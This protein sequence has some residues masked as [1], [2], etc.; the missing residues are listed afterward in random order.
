M[1]ARLLRTSLPL[2]TLVMSFASVSS[3]QP[4]QPPA[5]APAEPAAAGGAATGSELPPS[6]IQNELERR[7]AAMKA[8][9]GLTA[10]EVA[11]RALKN[12]QALEAKRH[13]LEAADAGVSQ[14]NAGYWPQLTASAR[15]TRLSSIEQANLGGGALVVTQVPAPNPR[16]IAAG[17]Q[18]FATNLSFP[19]LLNQYTL[20]LQLNVPLSD[21]LLRTS[22]AVGSAKHSRAAAELDE[23]GTR[24]SLARDARVAYYE[25]VRAQAAELIAAQGVEQAQG[26]LSDAQNAFQAGIV[27]RADVLR[28]E[29]ALQGAALFQER[30]RNASSLAGLRLKVLM[31]DE[32]SQ[33]YEVG[34]NVFAPLPELETAPSAESAYQEALEKRTELRSLE[35]AEAALRQQGQVARAGNY[36]RLDA[37]ANV[38]YANPNQRYFPQEDKWRGTWD[39]SLILSWTPT[40]IA[41]AQAQSSVLE[42]KAAEL[43]ANRAALRDALRLEV[44]Q[45]LQAV[46][47]ARF[48]IGASDHALRAAEESYRVRRELFRA[49]RSTM[50]EVTD[51]ETELTR[52]RLEAVDARVNARVALVA[53]NHALGRDTNQ[54]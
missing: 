1:K 34:E 49:G 23:R 26:H 11:R 42:A 54:R 2:A 25:W 10:S 19:V 13:A 46:G 6:K 16:P 48:A 45:A 22:R 44:S 20:N 37:Q 30:A 17:E 5:P 36:P 31:R 9:A 21:Y 18:L 8:G 47:E 14:A 38:T 41:G 32:Q 35:A 33:P 50:V 27:S 24:L 29:A 51:A 52:A 15:Y 12:S 28:A 40:N 3:A 39:A 43:A 4:L 7:L 53:L